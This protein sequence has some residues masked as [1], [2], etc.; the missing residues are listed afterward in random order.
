MEPIRILLCCGAGVSS[1]MLASNARKFAKKSKLPVVVEARS[2]SEVSEYLS[3]IDVLMLG[4]HYASQLEAFKKLAEPYNVAV[5]VIPQM[6][7]ATMNGEKLIE[8]AR[9]SKKNLV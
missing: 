9:D 7:Y 2:H 8:I 6:V 4:P 5:E 3:S 1:G